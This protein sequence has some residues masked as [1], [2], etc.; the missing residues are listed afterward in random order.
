MLKVMEEGA[1]REAR[2]ELFELDEIALAGARRM[3][4]AALKTEAADYV[5]RHRDE[6][7]ASAIWPGAN[8]FTSGSTGCTS[9]SGSK[10]TGSARWS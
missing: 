7:D 10:K 9:T 4:M 8:T 2:R 1:L 6:R 5:E 3:L